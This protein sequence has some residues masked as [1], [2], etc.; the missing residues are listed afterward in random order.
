MSD[1]PGS[2]VAVSGVAASGSAVDVRDRFPGLANG[3]ARFDGP[4]GTQVVDTAIDASADW[5][6]SGNNAN[7]HGAFAAAEA[8]DALVERTQATMGELLGADPAGFVFGPSTTN[9]VFSITRAIGRDLGPGDE[10]VCTRLDHDSNISPW[11]LIA[12]DTG[13]TVWMAD[14]DTAT[15]RLDTAAVT[16]LLGEHTRWVAV[17]GASNAIGTMPDIAAIT[18]AAHEVGAKVAVDG[19]HLTPHA[20][21]DL[22]AVGCDVYSTSSYKWYGPH[23]GITWVEPELLDRL[24][25]Y[26]VR[27][28]P[29]TGPGRLQLGTPAYES[30]AAIDAA[31]RFLIG[32]GMPTL[33]GHERSIFTRLLDGLLSMPNVRVVGPHDTSDRAPTLAFLV[34]GHT[35]NAVARA[36]AAREIAVWDG[37]YYAVEVMDSYGLDPESGAVR[38]GIAVYTDDSDVDRL[39]DAVAAL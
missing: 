35:P 26:K 16:A 33:A 18:A 7:S 30:L 39:L 31:A 8:C 22:R 10:I 32:V 23:A 11:L 29:A 34:D 15:G 17:T 36:L 28:S 12:A 24:Q 19:V 1:V 14:F 21:V 3:W 20:P 13:A 38:A 5:Q 4:A 9:N 37:N 2:G 6:R 25:V 27:P